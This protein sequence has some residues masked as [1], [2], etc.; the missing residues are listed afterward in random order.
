MSER[1]PE[2]GEAIR[3]EVLGDAW[4]DRALAERT[5]FDADFQDLITRYVWDEIWGRPGLDRRTRR[6][7]VLSTLTALGRW[8]ELALHLRAAIE[9]GVALDE[10][11]E[12]LMQC[13]IYAGVP[14]ART[15]MGVARKVLSELGR[16]RPALHTLRQGDGPPLV[17]AHSLGCDATLWDE[18]VAGLSRF[19]VL[20]YDAR[21]HG[22]SSVPPGPYRL[23]DL[24]DDAAR[25][26]R[27]WG[28][29]PVV[30]IGTSMGG[31]VAQGLAA[32]HPELV[33]ALVIAHSTSHYDE[34]ARTVWR[35]RIDAV[36]A[37]GLAAIA[38]AVLARWFT[39]S[40]HRQ[41]PD[42]VERF[43]RRLLATP[44][45]G[46]LACCEAIAGLDVRAGLP[47][48]RVPA[49]V[50]AGAEDQAIPPAAARAIA[51]AIPGARLVIL[52][53]AAHQGMI[54]Q[55]AAFAAAL[56]AFLDELS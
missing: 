50:I 21:G 4:V 55:P 29:G 46:Y 56:G 44:P 2:R 25:V 31:M 7:L 51:A 54:E 49:L 40:F 32:R 37:G 16:S 19:A 26:I 11:R 48:I 38:E 12:T 33:R 14:A 39:A 42:V 28:R 30:F 9:G 5:D 15:A 1:D 41:H 10:I 13:A 18:L 24:V 36:R 20:R 6:L 35:Q 22:R 53:G 43:R 45:E 3:R 8:D 34:A 23:D 52:E 17:L 47:G 27:A